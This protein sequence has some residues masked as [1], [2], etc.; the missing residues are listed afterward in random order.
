MR[1]ERVFVG[2]ILA[3]ALLLCIASESQTQPSNQ[4]PPFT[5]FERDRAVQMLENIAADVKKHY[6]DPKFHGI[7]WDA[8]VLE[9]KQRIQKSTTQNAALSHI[10]GALDSLHD[11]HTFF[12]PPSRPYVHDYGVQFQTIGDRCFIRRVRPGS[13]AEAKGIHAGDEVLAIDGYQPTRDNL[14]QMDYVLHTL[15]PELALQLDLRDPKGAER[16]TTASAKFRQLR[17]VK[18]LTAAGG[19]TDIWELFRQDGDAE[20]LN[21]FRYQEFGDDLLIVKFPSFAFSQSEVEGMLDK[22]RKHKA[23]IID[24]R[25]NGGGSVDTLKYLLSGLLES[26]TKIGDRVTRKETKPLI[27]KFHTHNPFTGKLL[28]LVDSGSASASEICARVVQLEKRGTV[29]G[30]RSSGK[31]MESLRYSYEA[32]MGVTV[33]YGAS[34]TEADVIMADGKSLENVGVVPDESMTPTGEDLASG[35][36]PVLAKAAHELGVSITAEQAGTFFP[37]EWPTEE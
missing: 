11:S 26:D 9:A 35:R 2:G 6:Y 7:D 22:A 8:R 4:Q 32:G 34:I 17:L 12:L 27:E 33:F 1:Q 16:Q 24:L 36:D 23:L 25:E 29:V 31:V 13:D 19:G 3:A 30:D 21:R 18:D 10:A 28:V 5:S 37:Y 14:W 20:H 15:R